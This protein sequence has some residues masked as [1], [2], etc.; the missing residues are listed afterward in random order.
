MFSAKNVCFA[1]MIAAL[2]AALTLLLQ[3]VSFG[4]VQ[5]RVA[6]ALTVL[7][8]LFPQAVPG[9]TLGC[10]IANLVGSGSVWDVVFGTLATL[11]AALLTRRLRSR[12]W[13]AALPPV[14]LNAVIVGVVLS[15]TL[16]D[17]LL[18]PTMGTIALGE[19]VVVY[20][21]GLPLLLALRRVPALKHLQM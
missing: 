3:A 19:A 13:L 11:F 21:L 16:G 15:L 1:G 8:E 9:L 18:L 14:I 4:P 10:L 6:E 17:T 5:F 7:P 12:D 2:Y 20:A